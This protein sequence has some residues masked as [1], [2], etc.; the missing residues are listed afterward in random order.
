MNQSSTADLNPRGLYIVSALVVM[1]GLLA[2]F[3]EGSHTPSAQPVSK[4]GDQGPQTA[5]LVASLDPREALPPEAAPGQA[6]RPEAQAPEAP[7]RAGA[8][9]RSAAP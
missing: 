4:S 8:R 5:P 6:R 9:T 2:L 7:P 3:P 1:L